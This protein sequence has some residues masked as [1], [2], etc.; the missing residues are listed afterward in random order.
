MKS[1]GNFL[2]I[3][4]SKGGSDFF[5]PFLC[6]FSSII[7]AIASSISIFFCFISL[8]KAE[9]LSCSAQS[10]IFFTSNFEILNFLDN[11]SAK[12]DLPPDGGPA[13]IILKEFN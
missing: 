5:L 6:S 7:F 13:I 3:D 9:S 12:D 11:I 8:D 10:K 2:N 4:I 1:L